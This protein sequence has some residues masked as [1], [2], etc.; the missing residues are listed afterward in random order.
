MTLRVSRGLGIDFRT[1]NT[2]AHLSKANSDLGSPMNP[3]TW[4]VTSSM[5]NVWNYSNFGSLASGGSMTNQYP[6]RFTGRILLISHPVVFLCDV[7]LQS[8]YS[9]SNNRVTS[10]TVTPHTEPH[11]SSS[12][13]IWYKVPLVGSILFI[14]SLPVYCWDDNYPNSSS[15]VFRPFTEINI[16]TIL[17]RCSETLLTLSPPPWT[18]SKI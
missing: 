9:T 4:S 2:P 10:P 18:Y 13:I 3:S 6:L 15:P 8:D 1:W 16:Q 7:V 5:R 12:I 11:L 14:L 17:F